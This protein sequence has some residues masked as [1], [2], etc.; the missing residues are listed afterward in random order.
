MIPPDPDPI[1]QT[2]SG[3][4]TVGF[5][6]MYQKTAVSMSNLANNSLDYLKAHKLLLEEV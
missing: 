6:H 1:K 5:T 2:S 4:S 3:I